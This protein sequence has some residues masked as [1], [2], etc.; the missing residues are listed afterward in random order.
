MFKKRLCWS[1]GSKNVIIMKLYPI[2]YKNMCLYTSTCTL[3]CLTRLFDNNGEP[4]RNTKSRS[5]LRR[6]R[7]EGLSI[8]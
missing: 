8:E 6:S 1:Y 7:V 2:P 3:G 5:D 4:R